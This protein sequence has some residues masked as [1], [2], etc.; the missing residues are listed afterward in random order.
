MFFDAPSLSQLKVSEFFSQRD[1]M[2][3]DNDE[4][5][6]RLK[7][8]FRRQ[9]LC[10][11]LKNTTFLSVAARV[12]SAQSVK[13]HFMGSLDRL[14]QTHQ[15][16]RSTKARPGPRSIALY[17][18]LWFECDVFPIIQT[19][20][21][22]QKCQWTVFVPHVVDSNREMVFVEVL[23]ADDFAENF[24]SR[25]PYG[26]REF[27]G[28]LSA[29]ARSQRRLLTS[30]DV[31]RGSL[32]VMLVPGVAFDVNT[33]A[34]LGK[35]G[36]YYDQFLNEAAAAAHRHEIQESPRV[37]CSCKSLLHQNMAI[38]GVGYD[39]QRLNSSLDADSWG[40]YQQRDEIIEEPFDFR[41]GYLLSPE[42]GL[43]VVGRTSTVNSTAFGFEHDDKQN[44]FC[45]KARSP[46]HRLSTAQ[47]SHA[48]C[49]QGPNR[50]QHKY[51]VSPI[52]FLITSL[53]LFWPV[54]SL[55]FLS[56]KVRVFRFLF[57]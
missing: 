24:T 18:P 55:S 12:N 31:G 9:M 23:S 37:L 52:A 32:D 16:Q 53:I 38:V 44:K 34:R 19:L 33:G 56:R 17:C 4:Y 46:R 15:S 14:S 22:H 49:L 3:W 41:V 36:G 6:S 43:E 25:P 35:G 5:K 51:V 40:L 8:S 10:G 28:E 47:F 39:C 45:R 7:A 11:I 21:S 26:I 54:I 50:F 20:L 29:R 2:S 57:P 42:N 13:T 27:R 48:Q 30:D 1:V